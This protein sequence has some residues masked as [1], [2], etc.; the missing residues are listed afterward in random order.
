M[1]KEEEKEY[2]K[3]WYQKNKGKVKEKSKKYREENSES[4]KEYQRDYREKNDNYFKEYNKS[5]YSDNKDV[6]S[7]RN[8]KWREDNKEKMDE[9]NKD[10]SIKNKDKLNDN[11]RKYTINNPEKVKESKNKWLNN[12]KEKRKDWIKYY[13]EKKRKEDPVFKIKENISCLLR[14]SFKSID[15]K[16]NIRTEEVIGCSIL[17]FKLYIENQFEDWMSWSNHG[18]YTG[19]YEETWQYDHIIPI[20]EAKTYEEVI[21]LNHYTNFRPLCSKKNLEKSNNRD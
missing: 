6:L 13:K 21:K 14:T 12:N 2:K 19:G 11:K 1:T 8:R 5:Y 18:S 4:I 9:Y 16:K 15:S 20:S 3:N 7:E 17:E 10:Y